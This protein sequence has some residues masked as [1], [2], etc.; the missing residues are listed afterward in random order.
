MSIPKTTKKYLDKKLAK[1]DELAHKTV[2]TAYDLAQTL[3]KEL[4]EI[5]KSLLIATDKAYILAVVPAHMRLDLGKLKKALKAKKVKIP[6]EKVMVKVFRVK[7]GAMTA[8]GGLHNIEVWVDKGLL[9]TKDVILGAGS[10]T[11]SVRMKARDFIKMEQAKL[12]DFAQKGGYVL[13]AKKPAK[14]KTAK[15]GK[16]AAKKAAKKKPAK[17][18]KK[19]KK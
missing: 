11:D 19:G 4:K 10:F 16:K 2:Y 17:S 9:K 7:P 12:A 8:F 14:K 13:Q 5:G 15:K 6:D 1:Y 3:R 18:K